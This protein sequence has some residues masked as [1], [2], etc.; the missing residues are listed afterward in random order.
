VLVKE[1]VVV[2]YICHPI[3]FG[4][5][6][7]RSKSKASPRQKCEIISKGITKAKKS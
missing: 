7:G 1:T 4:G 2:V 5:I 3:Y 6:V